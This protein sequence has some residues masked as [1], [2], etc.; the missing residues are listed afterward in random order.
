LV[1]RKSSCTPISSI[2]STNSGIIEVCAEVIVYL[3]KSIRC[4]CSYVKLS[5][6]TA[7]P[8]DFPEPQSASP[9]NNEVS[10]TIVEQGDIFFIKSYCVVFHL[11]L[12][13]F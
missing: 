13:L 2:F 11:S 4:P 10:A 7:T 12:L 1:M 3:L 6:N 9:R 8:K 5:K